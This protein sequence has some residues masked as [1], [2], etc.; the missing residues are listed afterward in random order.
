MMSRKPEQP[1]ATRA[2]LLVVLLLT[3]CNQAFRP[4][5]PGAATTAPAVATTLPALDEPLVDIKTVDPR[6][7][8]DVRYATEDNFM[9]RVLY[10]ANRVLL[11]ESVARRLSRVQDDLPARGLGLKVYDGYRPLSIQKMMWA[12]VANEDYVADPAK[13]SRHNR[14]AAVDAT[15]VDAAGR[16]LEMPS[17]YDEFSERARPTYQG[18]PEQARRNRDLLIAIMHKHGFTVLDTEWWHFDAPGWESYPIMDT[19]LTMTNDEMPM[20]KE[21]QMTKPE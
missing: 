10:P 6:I 4:Q 11:R 5:Q 9:H 14:G 3:G 1:S 13:G 19:P 18:G 8:V 16:E 17:G 21:T 2:L 20:T 15:L 7:L 12:V